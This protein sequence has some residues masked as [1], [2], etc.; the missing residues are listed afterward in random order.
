MEITWWGIHDAKGVNLGLHT[1]KALRTLDV[2]YKGRIPDICP[3]EQSPLRCWTGPGEQKPV[4]SS[5]K[6]ELP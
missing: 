3:A 4:P 6:E 2:L 1:V 5:G